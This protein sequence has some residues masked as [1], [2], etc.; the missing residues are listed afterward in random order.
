MHMLLDIRMV[1]AWYWYATLSG[2]PRVKQVV[3]CMFV[4]NVW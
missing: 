4:S 2:V 1:G 3:E